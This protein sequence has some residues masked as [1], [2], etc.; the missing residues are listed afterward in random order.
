MQRIASSPEILNMS[1]KRSERAAVRGQARSEP[2]LAPLTETTS[3][4]PASRLCNVGMSEILAIGARA[5]ELQI[6]GRDIVLLGAGEPDF[7]TPDAVKLAA[8]RAIDDDETHYTPLAGTPTLLKAVQH[9]LLRDNQ[10]DY[11]PAELIAAAGAKQIIF[12]ALLATL[13]PG[14]EV[15]VPAPYWAS[16]PDMVRVCSGQ[17]VVVPCDESNGFKLQPEALTHAITPRTRWLLLNYPSNPTGAVYT[18]EELLGLAEVLAAHPHVWVV[19]DEIYEQLIFDQQIHVSLLNIAPAL[20]DRTLLVNGV[21]KSH[22]MTGWRLGYGAGP[23]A[24][25]KAMT[26]IQSQSTSAPSSISQAAAVE[27][28]LDIDPKLAERRDI[29]QQRRD[30]VV[31]ALSSIEGLSCAQPSGA[32]YAYVRCSDV[33][34]K[35]TPGGI[36][37]ET[38]SDFCRYALEEYGIALVPGEAFGASPYFRLS[39]ATHMTRLLMGL[40]RLACAADSLF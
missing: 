23:S 33:I 4:R 18:P 6:L 35:H 26:A 10:L 40:E 22:A 12:N 27:A 34:G 29:Y 20:R 11:A 13:D 38:D 7:A 17:P 21:S 30:W 5:K 28:L 1:S 25:V 39:F 2:T 36:Q 14:D 19:A 32:F 24:L 9:K 15:I 16:Y 31:Q 3:F 8:H 37:I